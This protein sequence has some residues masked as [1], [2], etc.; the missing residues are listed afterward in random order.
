MA[1]SLSPRRLARSSAERP[2][3]VVALWV[4]LF[5][6]AGVVSAL[7]L[8][9]ALTSEISFTNDPESIRGEQLLSDRMPGQADQVSET[10][11]VRSE[12][13][14]VDDAAFERVVQDVTASLRGVE[15]ISLFNV[16]EAEANGDPMAA[17]LVSADGRA[18][19]LPIAFTGSFD[20]AAEQ[21]DPFTEA[22]AASRVVGYEVLT[23][24]DLSVDEEF[25]AIAE[26]DL[27]T[28]ELFGLPM[29]MVILVVV[30]GALVA[31]GVPII[32]ALISIAVAVGLTAVIGQVIE[33]SFF[34]VNMITMIGLAVGIDYALFI[35]DRYR[36]ERRRGLPKVEAITFAGG[37]ASRAVLFSGITVVLA[38]SGMLLIPTT[39]FQSLGLGAILAV[40]VAVAASLT[41][42]P[43]MLSLLGDRI[44]W[45]RRR[46]YDEATAAAQVAH[47]SQTYHDG[48]WGRIAR[49][50]M[51]RPA[52][53]LILAAAL[54]VAAAIPYFGLE[55]GQAG[56]ATLPES[57]VKQAFAI[58]NQEFGAGRLAPVE[59]A[60]DGPRSPEVQAGIDRLQTGLAED[61]RFLPNQTTVEWNEAGD[62][63]LLTTSLA[64]DSN[65]PGA[66]TAIHELREEIVPA[67]LTGVPAVALVTGDT[68]FNAD[69][70]TVVDDWTPIV[71]A[72][73]LALSF[74]LLLLA[75]R[76]V[77]IPIKAIVLNLL[78]VGAAYGLMV[79][80]FQQGVGASLLGFQETPTIEAW[81]PI[82]LFCV[83]FGLSMDYEV[84]LLSR[85]KEHYDITGRNAESVAV[86]LQATA[87]IITGAALIM[88]VVFTGFAMGRLVMFQQ[89]GFGLA[90]A[91]FLDATIVRSVLVPAG[92]ALL[93]K[94]NW[95][96]PSWL[97][98]LP[99]VSIEGTPRETAVQ[100]RDPFQ[101]AAIPEGAAD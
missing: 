22:L 63:A 28:A 73:V 89:M 39:I 36:E 66:N 97:A 26:S 37:T 52:L 44:D 12:S 83:L 17:G 59:I 76:S 14:T 77:V 10:V 70:F 15:G 62:L 82:F 31:A 69:F 67:A 54:L 38:L 43:A 40:I 96:L 60:I 16:Y 56:I 101:P 24:G 13:A 72:F 49:V 4:L 78:S 23:V 79:L 7:W 25:N 91:V 9:D 53:S 1:V 6:F 41:L 68:A 48:F 42:V 51:A 2:R 3:R 61:G 58:L 5:A 55:R 93:G 21:L 64:M 86:G 88:V 18:T 46:R 74:I 94:W 47:D 85:I 50:V 34:V 19:L 90:V 57:D 92:M 98:W 35:V 81:V 11:I 33:L 80:V 84:F 32:L 8:G 20:E 29:A 27:Q 95:Y 87:R 45:P 75:F 100:P 65:D 99:N 71:F 30:F